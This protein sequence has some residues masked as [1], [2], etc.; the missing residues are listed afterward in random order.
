MK[1]SGF[2]R[3]LLFGALL[4][5]LTAVFTAPTVQA[6]HGGGGEITLDEMLLKLKEDGR[7]ISQLTH[8]ELEQLK[9]S[10]GGTWGNLFNK[11]YVLK[12]GLSTFIINMLWLS[13]LILIS[14]SIVLFFF[15]PIGLA[16]GRGSLHYLAGSILKGVRISPDLG[17]HLME[18]PKKALDKHKK[19]R[20]AFAIYMHTN[21]IPEYKNN[22]TAI[23]FMGTAFLILSIGLRGVKFMTAH[24]PT[25][26]VTALIIEITVLFLLGLTTWYEKEE[27]EELGK[28][29]G[30]AGKQL[31]LADVERRLDQLKQ[32]LHSTVDAQRGLRQ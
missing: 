21:F 27:E 22:V 2:T 5:A 1:S 7:N 26:I 20:K 30:F 4:L 24:E 16:L 13:I 10:T 19:V 32:E 28:E 9:E 3:H 12:I 14:S 25:W 18:L 23:A 11:Q 31:S 15:T 17:D 29:P 8:E 6:Q